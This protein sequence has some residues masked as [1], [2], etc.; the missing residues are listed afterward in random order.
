MSSFVIPTN[1]P[2]APRN[3]TFP[4]VIYGSS[5]DTLLRRDRFI[6]ATSRRLLFSV[7]NYSTTAAGAVVVYQGFAPL[8]AITTKKFWIV[9]YAEKGTVTV[10]LGGTWAATYGVTAEAKSAL[11]TTA[12]PPNIYAA[13]TVTVTKTA[14]QPYVN[15]YG[16]SVYEERLSTIDLP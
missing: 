5:M 8:S 11:V 13:F 16:L 3:A 6:Y 9:G 15:L 1:D 14:G 2:G 4:D 12:L 10:N 7:P